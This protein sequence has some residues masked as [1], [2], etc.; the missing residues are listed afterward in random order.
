M[1]DG[2]TTRVA[3]ITG[4]AQGIGKAIALRLANDGYD[5]SLNDIPPQ[6]ER[7]NQVKEEIEAKGRKVHVVLGDVSVEADVQRIVDDT[8]S[9]FGSVDVVSDLIWNLLRTSYGLSESILK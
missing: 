5:I 2:S 7:L 6:L 8:A 3:V 9:T 1:A 4:A